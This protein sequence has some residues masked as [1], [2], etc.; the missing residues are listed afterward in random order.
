MIARKKEN[1]WLPD[2]YIR[3]STKMQKQ[4]SLDKYHNAKSIGNYLAMQKCVCSKDAKMVFP[5][6]QETY[7]MAVE[8]RRCVLLSRQKPSVDMII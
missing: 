2:D 1:A 5:L 3:P 7:Y 6:P 4:I 8:C